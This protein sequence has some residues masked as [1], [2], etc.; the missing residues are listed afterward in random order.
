MKR[1][2]YFIILINLCIIC[3]VT[4]K[5]QEP[6]TESTL[7]DLF[8]RI[9]S[10][11]DDSIRIR[12][13]DSINL[14]VQR[15][16]ASDIV[17]THRFE[18]LRY[19]GQILSPDS[20]IKIITWN[21]ILTDGSNRYCCYIIKKGE[22]GAENNIYRLEGKNLEEPPRT[23]IT[24][25]AEKWYG[26]LYYAIRPFKIRKETY[27]IVLGLDYGSLLVSRKIIDV[28]SFSGEDGIIFG[29]S[30]FQKEG[31]TKLREVLEYSADGI[32]TLR[33]HNKKTIVFDHLVP[34]SSGQKYDQDNY[35]SEFS[36]DAYIYNKGLWRFV[37]NVDIRS[38]Q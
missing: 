4:L 36:Y 26:A 17:F 33:F 9:L 7:G 2:A 35:G 3:T 12:I 20:R 19:L 31:E 32:M 21:L 11:R 25:T 30:C 15:Y 24:Y 14:I 29:K 34:I 1:K 38:K 6:G 10:T 16:V 13:N 23:D 28:M 18:N 8:S 22:K 5:A 37:R 27:Y